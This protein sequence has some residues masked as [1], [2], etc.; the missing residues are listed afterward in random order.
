MPMLDRTIS[1]NAYFSMSPFLFWAVIGVACRSYPKDRSLLDRLFP[2]VIDLALSSI[3]SKPNTIHD[4]KGLLLVVSWRFTSTSL[5]MDITHRLSGTMLH[6]AM[7]M[8]LHQL[9]ASQDFSKY[10]LRNN[11]VDIKE[12]AEVWGHCVVVYQR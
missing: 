11:D 9:M 12:R 3:K 4:I 6:M 1:S 2:K 5:T 10:R 8:G 7:Q